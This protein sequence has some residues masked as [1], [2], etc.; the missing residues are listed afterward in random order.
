MSRFATCERILLSNPSYPAA[1][2]I[3][4]APLTLPRMHPGDSQ[5][6]YVAIHCVS[7]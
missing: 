1:V 7:A 5:A 2:R 4:L 6:T 3:V